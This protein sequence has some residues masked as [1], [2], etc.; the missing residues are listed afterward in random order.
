MMAAVINACWSAWGAL[1]VL[2]AIAPG[3]LG[4]TPFTFGVVLTANGAGGAI[5]ALLAGRV[6]RWL[7]W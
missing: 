5:G 1:L 2:Y 6:Q 3:P 4:L 7:G